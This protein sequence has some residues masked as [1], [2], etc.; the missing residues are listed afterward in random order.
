MQG[1]LIPS[2]GV[3]DHAYGFFPNVAKALGVVR[4]LGGIGFNAFPLRFIVLNFFLIMFDFLFKSL[5]VCVG[6]KE[7]TNPQG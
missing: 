3:G 6:K 7:R 5:G 2:F 4:V 1:G